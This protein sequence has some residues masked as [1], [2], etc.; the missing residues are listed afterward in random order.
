MIRR[1][2][3]V[4]HRT[5]C[6]DGKPGRFPLSLDFGLV[7]FGVESA[8]R[9]KKYREGLYHAGSVKKR[10]KASIRT[11]MFQSERE[12]NFEVD[13]SRRFRSRTR[14]FTDSGIIDS[15]AFGIRTYEI[16]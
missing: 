9:L 4:L 7:E 2:S 8:E 1:F 16:L 15:K 10:G 11:R 12:K 3:M 13:R 14:Y 6:A 5:P